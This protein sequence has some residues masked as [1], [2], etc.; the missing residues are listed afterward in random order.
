MRPDVQGV[1]FNET[2]HNGVDF[3]LIVQEGHASLSIDS[4]PGYVLDH[5]PSI[6][7]VGIQEGSLGLMFY[8]SGVL[9]WSTFSGVAFV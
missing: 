6:K 5:V 4:Y 1:I 7:G 8:T 3:G 9:S 2:W